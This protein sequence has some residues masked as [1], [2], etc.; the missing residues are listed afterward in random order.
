MAKYV[1]INSKY[2]NQVIFLGLKVEVEFHIEELN[3]LYLANC[4]SY[5][6]FLLTL[7]LCITASKPVSVI[8]YGTFNIL[9]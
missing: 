4:I 3:L 8:I 9:C 7:I 2:F 6:H 5:Y 1:V